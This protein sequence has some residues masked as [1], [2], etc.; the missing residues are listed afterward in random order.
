MNIIL[1]L[2]QTLKKYNEKKLLIAAFFG[3]DYIEL[4]GL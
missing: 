3:K 1:I 2:T 4:P